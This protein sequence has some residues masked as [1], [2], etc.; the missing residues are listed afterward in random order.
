[1]NVSGSFFLFFFSYSLCYFVFV[2]LDL[3]RVSLGIINCIAF[4]V[5]LH[6]SY[7]LFSPTQRSYNTCISM[8]KFLRNLSQRSYKA[9]VPRFT[10]F[11]DN[12]P[13][14]SHGLYPKND[15]HVP[16]VSLLQYMVALVLY[17]FVFVT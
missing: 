14:A 3:D 17:L 1:M 11:P 15:T 7:Y 5:S 2:S 12:S 13:R 6:L 4:I 10:S 16:H 9:T 8:Q